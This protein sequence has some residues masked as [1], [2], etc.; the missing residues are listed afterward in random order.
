MPWA[1][2]PG[3]G[4][5][6]GEPWLPL[7]PDI[8][9]VNVERQAKDPDSMLNLY[10]RLLG[11]RRR[12]RALTHGDYALAALTRSLWAYERRWAEDRVLVAL[13]LGGEGGELPLAAGEVLLSTRHGR[14]GEP[15]QGA[16]RLGPNEGLI[17]RR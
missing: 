9:E 6:S 17:I 8:A 13:D 1:D 16:L 10:R 15:V 11:L 4:F 12:E 2:A 7:T 5:T 3:G 14:E